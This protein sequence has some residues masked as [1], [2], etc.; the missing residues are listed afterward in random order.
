MNLIFLGSSCPESVEQELMKLGARMDF[1]GHTLQNALLAGF[2]QLTKKI[3]IITSWGITNF[4][5]VKKICFGRRVMSYGDNKDNY[6]YVGAFNLPLLDKLYRYLK[7]KRELKRMLKNGEDN[8]L[9]VYGV[10]SPFLLAAVAHRKRIKHINVI[11]PDLPEFMSGNTGKLHL[12]LKKIDHKIITRCLKKIDSYSLLSEPMQERLPMEGKKW[13]LMEG[14]YQ[15]TEEPILSE[16]HPNKVVMYTGGIYHRRGTDLLL[17]AFKL[18]DN[19][20]YRLWIR[21]NG[22][23]KSEILEMAKSDPRIVYFE[24]VPRLELLKMEK[25]A[26]C[27]INPTMPSLDFTRY[28]FPSKTME[29]LASGTPTIMFHLG[30]MPKEYDEHLFY[31]ENETPESMRDKIVEVCEMDKDNLADFGRKAQEFVLSEKTPQK[32]CEKILELCRQ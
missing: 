2:S 27:M 20:D 8:V 19:P 16:K 30:C 18:I 13:C 14:I 10:Q 11:V 22:D 32:Q 5:K 24:P 21:G 9:V 15:P 29:Y 25:Q 26:T 12:F 31:I 1:P 3:N 28:F 4:P 23:M 17:E 7:V 6:I